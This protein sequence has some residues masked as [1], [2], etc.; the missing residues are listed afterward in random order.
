MGEEIGPVIRQPTSSVKKK[1]DYPDET[2]GN[3]VAATVRREASRLT[4]DQRRDLFKR[5]MVRIYG[6]QPKETIG[7]GH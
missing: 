2:N 5:A 6:G 3:R 7:V 4:A 1:L